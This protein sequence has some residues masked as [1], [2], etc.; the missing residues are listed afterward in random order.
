MASNVEWRTLSDDEL[1]EIAGSMGVRAAPGGLA[2]P[3]PE[4]FQAQ[5]ELLRRL[6]QELRDTRA[7][8]ETSGRT[9]KRL[10]KWLVVLTVALVVL[11]VLLVG[12]EV[13]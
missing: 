13:I 9:M 11:T 3:A 8:L 7:E 4:G 10:T 6:A 2:Q 12:L 1:V 5:G